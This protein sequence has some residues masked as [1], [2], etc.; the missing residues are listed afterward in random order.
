MTFLRG[1]RALTTATRA[2]ADRKQVNAYPRKRLKCR[3]ERARRWPVGRT[4][5]R[6][7]DSK[8]RRKG[9]APST[10]S[11]GSLARA[12]K[13]HHGVLAGPSPSVETAPVGFETLPAVR[14][15]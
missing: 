13:R 14:S 15:E 11:L 2:F 3:S 4:R 5:P 10:P 12:L 1:L 7:S 8:E 6:V 9:F